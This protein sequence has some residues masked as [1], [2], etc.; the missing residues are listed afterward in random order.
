MCTGGWDWRESWARQIEECDVIRC[1]DG[2]TLGTFFVSTI[3]NDYV[4]F[5]ECL[6]TTSPFWGWSGTWETFCLVRIA[7]TLTFE[8][9]LILAS[10]SSII[11][12][13]AEGKGSTTPGKFLLVCWR[14]DGFKRPLYI[15][16][17]GR[18][19]FS[20]VYLFLFP[21]MKRI[22]ICLYLCILWRN[23]F[24]S[25]KMFSTPPP[26][27]DATSLYQR[28]TWWTRFQPE[29]VPTLIGMR[30]LPPQLKTRYYMLEFPSTW[31][32]LP[33]WT[34]DLPW[35][36]PVG[37]DIL[38]WHKI[39]DWHVVKWFTAFMRREVT[40]PMLGMEKSGAHMLCCY[41]KQ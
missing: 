19:V 36:V 13:Y 6:F 29:A 8:T 3:S 1:N 37:I 12:V 15:V 23:I 16:N 11:N 21:Q 32:T 4:L 20:R 18:N 14:K 35:V 39:D 22:K 38:L 27:A 40:L 26:L 41:M 31:A 33:L 34:L 9:V 28:C 5:G 2:W 30:V 7:L 10:S 25:Q 17:C 24:L